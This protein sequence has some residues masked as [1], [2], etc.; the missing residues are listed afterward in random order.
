ML[1]KQEEQLERRETLDNDRLVREQ[2]STFLF[3]THNELI[4][5]FDGRHSAVRLS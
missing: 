1:S 3:H 4:G 2:G 5:G